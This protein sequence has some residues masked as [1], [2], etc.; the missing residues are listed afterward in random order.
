MLFSRSCY[1][2]SV[3]GI[4]LTIVTEAQRTLGL[5]RTFPEKQ[6]DSPLKHFSHLGMLFL[7]AAMSASALDQTT[8]TTIAGAHS[9]NGGQVSDAQ[10][11]RPFHVVFDGSGNLYIADRDISQVRKVDTSGVI[12][13]VAGTNLAGGSG[14]GGSATSARLLYPQGLCFA[15]GNLYISDVGNSRIRKVNSLGNISTVAGNGNE[16]YSGDGN[17]ATVAQLSVPQGVVV[18]AAG[19]IYIADT[20]NN[21]VR[22]V[23]ATGKIST[24][25]GDG[26]GQPGYSGDTGA[27][28]SARLNQPTRVAL[29]GNGHL[30]IADSANLCARQVNL[31][32]NIITTIFTDTVGTDSAVVDVGADGSGNVYVTTDSQIYK[33]DSTSTTTVIA[34]DGTNPGNSVD[35]PATSTGLWP[36]GMS[37]D[38][39]GK[40]YLVEETYSRLRTISGGNLSTLSGGTRGDNGPATSA[41]VVRVIGLKG[42]KNG[43]IY[44]PDFHGNRVRKID[45][46]G[47]IT[48]FA[49]TGVNGYSGDGNPATSAQLALPADVV[50]DSIGNVYIS[51]NGNGRIRKVALD[52]T[53]STFFTHISDPYALAIDSAD[54]IYVSNGFD[55]TVFK[56]TPAGVIS[57]FAGISG[58]GGYNGDGGA[59][60]SATLNLPLGLAADAAGNV[61][62]ADT[63]NNRIRK[64]DT[65]GTITTVVGTGV[66]GYS[67]DNGPASS[68]KINSPRSVAVDGA[69]RLYVTDSQ[70]KLIRVVE[71]GTITTYVGNGNLGLSGDGGP[72]T[73]AAIDFPWGMWSNTAGTELLFWDWERFCVRKITRPDPGA[74]AYNA[75]LTTNED[76]VASGTLNARDGDAETLTFSIVNSGS[77]G[78][79]VI[80]NA[81]TGAFTYT[82]ILNANGTDSFTF[83]ANDGTVDSNTATITVTITAVNDAPFASRGSLTTTENTAKTGVL[84]GTDI[85]SSTLTYS[86]VTNGTKGTASINNAA[87]GFYTYTPNLNASGSDSF[88]FKANDGALDSN[89]ATITV[90]ITP[91]NVAPVIVSA[92]LATPSA[93]QVGATVSFSVAAS[94]ADGDPLTYAWNF[95]DGS[96]G[97]GALTEHVYTSPGTFTTQVNVT[98]PAGAGAVSSA[99]V[100]VSP[101]PTPGDSDGDGFPDAI[102]IALGTDPLNA[103]STPFG[104]QLAGAPVPFAITQLNIGLNFARPNSDTL[105]LQG[106]VPIPADFTALGQTVALDVGGIVR[107]FTLDKAGRGKSGTAQIQV[108]SRSGA[109]SAKLTIKF[110]KSSLAADLADDGL[111]SQTVTKA[112][113]SVHVILL[114]DATNFQTDVN[115]L[116]TAKA[117]KTGAGKKQ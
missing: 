41:C 29:D 91:V 75:A 57:P 52:G 8:I 98:D 34:G 38:A 85:D 108:A 68:A 25:A 6:M 63:L 58:N 12:S 62:I 39:S 94:D 27:A 4:T 103:A 86:I 2:C 32:T 48:T 15:N 47:T 36:T 37:V 26:T 80:T 111:T 45:S 78:T 19:V 84:V 70:N 14:D 10:L 51:E 33:I 99:V 60:T 21:C 110:S 104:G 42:D 43:N 54:N 116:Y 31:T 81:A 16:G 88:T 109:T 56:I 89:V 61:Y 59:A 92:A 66:A 87:T 23:D 72:A 93:V 115:L 112:P 13:I 83:K 71:N 55:H 44:L 90:T 114:L 97:S 35:G 117:G 102:E 106:S 96:F 67:G 17:T 79:A 69:G 22:K 100:V 18:D 105:T 82:P 50:V 24:F 95:G 7:L 3:F 77:K 53:I 11:Y 64:V 113:K 101:L 65:S 49:G 46:G 74:I 9:N 40:I 107:V 1:F 5:I 73:S 76:T 28:T 30:L 20:G